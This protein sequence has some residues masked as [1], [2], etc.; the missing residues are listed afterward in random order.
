MHLGGRCRRGRAQHQRSWPVVEAIVSVSPP[1][2]IALIWRLRFNDGANHI[3]HHPTE[4]PPSSEPR[5][6]PTIRSI[7]TTLRLHFSLPANENVRRGIDR[8]RECNPRGCD[9]SQAC[10][11]PLFRR[12]VHSSFPQVCSQVLEAPPSVPC[13][14]DRSLNWGSKSFRQSRFGVTIRLCLNHRTMTASLDLRLVCS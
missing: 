14:L 9:D 5:I 12:A 13:G 11:A 2:K 1:R 4:L 8:R 7:F 3:S 6:L 10:P